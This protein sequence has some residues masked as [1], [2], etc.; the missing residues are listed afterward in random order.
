MIRKQKIDLKD[1]NFLFSS[2]AINYVPRKT[3]FS[4]IVKHNVF[5]SFVF[6]W[7]NF[8]RKS[9]HYF[10]S[11]KNKK[12]NKDLIF[13]SFTNNQRESASALSNYFEEGC[14]WGNKE[15][16]NNIVPEY[17]GYFYA[18]KYFFRTVKQYRKATGYYKLSFKL[19]FWQYWLSYG[20]LVMLERFITKNN[21]KTIVVTNDH[22]M[23]TRAVTYLANRDKFKSV[24][25]QH[26]SVTYNFPNLR[27]D[28]AL[29][30]GMD[31]F[32]KY[33]KA[34]VI[35]SVV[36]I[37]GNLK[38]TRQMKLNKSSKVNNIGICFGLN[39]EED[40]ITQ[41]VDF[42]VNNYSFTKVVLRPHPGE[43]RLQFIKH[44]ESQ[45]EIIISDSKQE[46]VNDFL[47]G[48]D[49]VVSGESN[50]HLDAIS[51]NIETVYFE[52]NEFTD[53][54]SFIENELIIY[55]S[56]NTYELNPILNT[57]SKGKKDCI[58]RAKYYDALIGSP[59]Y[60]K[61]QMLYSEVI[62]GIHNNNFEFIDKHFSPS[63]KD[64]INTYTLISASS[65]L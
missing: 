25:Y 28:Y 58:Q 19:F 14:F 55:I 39:D 27:F 7:A 54:Y 23:R 65:K 11:N 61:S 44:L 43:S 37:V 33:K 34:G 8:I 53:S 32:D 52:L 20:Y 51:K 5:L 15:F 2:D 59:F 57:L 60:G 62:K 29:L 41:L 24:Y 35:D 45:F 49:C 63:M 42:I 3:K 18:V 40:K 1:L 26:A 48:I 46:R 56:K 4:K 6:F 38:R 30:E 10:S 9:I 50:I 22:L 13:L 21:I 16:G 17:K 64:G 36:F 12:V 47:D 31:A